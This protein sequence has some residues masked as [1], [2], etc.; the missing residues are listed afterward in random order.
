[1]VWLCLCQ[2]ASRLECFFC[3]SWSGGIHLRTRAPLNPWPPFQPLRRLSTFTAKRRHPH[4]SKSARSAGKCAPMTPRWPLQAMCFVT[5]VYM[6]ILKPITGVLSLATLQDCSTSLKY[7]HLMDRLVKSVSFCF[8]DALLMWNCLI[9][10]N[11]GTLFRWT[12]GLVLFVILK[13]HTH[14]DE[15][16]ARYSPTFNASWLNKGRQCECAHRHE[17]RHA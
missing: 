13:A 2:A 8:Q 5:S 10:H 7:T 15:F 9:W 6:C 14:R 1:M 12:T 11:Y 16:R 4:T 17:K 3:S